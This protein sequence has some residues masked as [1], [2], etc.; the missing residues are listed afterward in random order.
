MPFSSQCLTATLAPSAGTLRTLSV[1][2]GG[3][4]V[5]CALPTLTGSHSSDA[6]VVAR[7]GCWNSGT[8]RMSALGLGS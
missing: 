2:M 6:V 3:G 7:E 4:G 8:E 5:I 1:F